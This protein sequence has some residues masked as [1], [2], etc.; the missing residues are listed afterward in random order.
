MS[1]VLGSPLRNLIAG[2]VFLAVV[3]VCSVTAYVAYGWPLGDALYMVITTVY[4][5]GYEEVRPIDTP[6]LRAITMALIVCGCTGVIFLTGTFVQ[7]ITFSQFQQFSDIGAC[8]RTS[9][10]FPATW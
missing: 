6:V 3:C 5:V 8:R 9:T 2:L 1:G 4:T 10:G 7:L